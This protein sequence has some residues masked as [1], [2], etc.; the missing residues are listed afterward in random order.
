MSHP[1]LRLDCHS[2]AD[3]WLV[4]GSNDPKPDASSDLLVA[5]REKKLHVYE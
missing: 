2:I 1:T 5:D 3:T 4:G